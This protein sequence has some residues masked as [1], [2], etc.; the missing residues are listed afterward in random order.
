MS[1]SKGRLLNNPRLGV[2]PNIGGLYEGRV[3]YNSDPANL[4]RIK[5]RI[6][7]INNIDPMMSINSY[8]IGAKPNADLPNIDEDRT[9]PWALP[10]FMPG[11]FVVPDVGDMVIVAFRQNNPRKPVYL[12]VIYNVND[13]ITYLE[14]ECGRL[15]KYE[16]T[17]GQ[18]SGIGD[19]QDIRPDTSPEHLDRIT[20]KDYYRN[21]ITYLRPQGMTAPEETIEECSTLDPDV[22]VFMKT[23]RGHTIY[24]VDQSESEKLQILD[25]FG[26]TLKFEGAAVT[27]LGEERV[28]KQNIQRRGTR[29][30][31]TPN[32]VPLK[33]AVNGTTKVSLLDALGQGIRITASVLG[34]SLLEIV[35]FGGLGDFG[36]KANEKDGSLT[37][38]SPKGGQLIV[39][40]G[41]TATDSSGGKIDVHGGVV[42]LN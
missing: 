15:G 11:S 16:N 2:V 31:S 13:N 24:A 33:Y 36:L 28:N 20:P 41:F 27:T 42:K 39:N 10:C 21:D 3:V 32:K 12:G 17:D 9:L 7:G 8:S 25:R 6:V 5:I 19:V 35:G 29:D 22:K 30:A 38:K 1:S 4:G 18:S 40:D 34:E 37:I 23:K 26:Q 14:N